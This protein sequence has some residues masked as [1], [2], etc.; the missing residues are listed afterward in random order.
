MFQDPDNQLFSADVYGEISFG[1]L[2]LGLPEDEARRRVEHVLQELN[3]TPFADK[4]VHLL[5]GGQKKL[6]AIAD[7]L[8]MQPEVVLL[9][10]PATALDPR[11]AHMVDDVIDRMSADGITVIIST[12]DVN[13]ALSWADSVVLFDGGRVLKK[14]TPENIFLNDAC[15]KQCNLEPPCVMAIYR[16]LLETGMLPP[17]LPLPHNNE[18]LIRSIKSNK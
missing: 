16:S 11:H 18:D 6:I 12:H 17:G 9:D 15:L 7:V 13:R 8:V 14:D 2:N 3:L 4:P 5:S 1:A 10:E